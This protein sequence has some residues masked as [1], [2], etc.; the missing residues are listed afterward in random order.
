MNFPI[1]QSNRLLV[2][3]SMDPTV[4]CRYATALLLNWNLFCR[5]IP[6]QEEC[7]VFIPSVIVGFFFVFGATDNPVLDF[8]WCHIWVSKPEWEALFTLGR[9]ICLQIPWDSHLV[10]HLLTSWQPSWHLRHSL[11]HTF[12]QALV[13]LETGIYR[14]PDD[15]STDWAMLAR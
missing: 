4:S 6:G 2:L 12:K 13:G 15:C 1:L 5:N 11:S 9:D 7:V 10:Q 3:I 8:W 14:P